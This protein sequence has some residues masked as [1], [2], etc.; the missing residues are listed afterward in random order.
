MLDIYEYIA[1]LGRENV[2]KKIG[3]SPIFGG[4][5]PGRRERGGG[6]Q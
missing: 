1:L 5:I 2:A 4:G 3:R 6:L